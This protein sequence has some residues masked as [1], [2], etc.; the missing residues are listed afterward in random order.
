MQHISPNILRQQPS[1]MCAYNRVVE[2]R[3]CPNSECL[4]ELSW[5][6]NFRAAHSSPVRCTNCKMVIVRNRRISHL[7][8][9]LG[10]TSS[11]WI[12]FLLFSLSPL[13]SIA[14]IPAVIALGLMAGMVER[15]R[16]ALTYITDEEW[17]MHKRQ[18]NVRSLLGFAFV[19]GFGLLLKLLT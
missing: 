8:Y 3:I 14:Y 15:S 12:A 18:R 11:P 16:N 4:S 2:D 10:L 5:W 6:M 1:T 9:A 7:I 19:V 17:E 13:A